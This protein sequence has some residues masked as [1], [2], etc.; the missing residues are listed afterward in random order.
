MD[1]TKSYPRSPKAKLAGVVMLAR[2][3]DKARAHLAGTDGPYHFGCGMDKHVLSFLG[4]EPEAFAKTVAE[5][6]EDAKIEAWAR[7]RLAGKQPADIETFNTEFA[8]DGPE[9]GGDAEAFFRSER[10]RLGRNDIQTWF[11]LLDVDENRPVPVRA[12]A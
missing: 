7:Q 6:G 12:A 11:E 1:L 4:S 9:P 5:L 10:Q 8:Q 2:T 3:T